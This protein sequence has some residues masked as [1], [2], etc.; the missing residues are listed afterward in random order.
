MDPISTLKDAQ[1]LGWRKAAIEA[2]RYALAE[3][4][5]ELIWRWIDI[6]DRR[7]LHKLATDC[8]HILELAP[9]ET[10]GI[11]SPDDDA[12]E[13]FRQI[14][15]EYRTDG[16]FVCEIGPAKLVGD[17]P[18]GVTPDGQVIAETAEGNERNLKYRVFDRIREA[19]P[20]RAL[21]DLNGY[22]ASS[23][24]DQCQVFPIVRYPD[25]TTSYYHW[26]LGFAYK[27]RALEQYRTLTGNDPTVLIE[28]E[29]PSW[30][31]GSLDLLG[32]DL[33]ECVR[34]EG[35]TEYVD[36]LV[37]PSHNIRSE[38]NYRPSVRECEWI[39]ERM[40]QNANARTRNDKRVY[41]SRADA[42]DRYVSNEA[43]VI[44][45]LD[46]YGFTSYELSELSVAEQVR[47]FARADVILGAHGAG[48][49]NMIFSDSPTVIELIPESRPKPF[50]FALAS[51]LEYDYSYRICESDDSANISV[52]LNTLDSLLENIG[53]QTD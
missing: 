23:E 31:D 37:V 52:N 9:D 16:Q 43:D 3:A 2:P 51:E 11:P 21:A 1:A 34:W 46:E 36:S 26:L 19:G 53:I 13:S 45:M 50:Y 29:A 28:S 42:T 27:V 48:L 5:I 32:V 12:P 44:E 41:I 30:V 7:G 49:V 24:E 25:G 35:G 47:L 18:L 14:A 40:R 33:G 4:S 22:R 17:Q 10:V 8:G 20:L 38:P 6:L 15:G 39:S